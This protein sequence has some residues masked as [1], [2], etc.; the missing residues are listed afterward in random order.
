MV[1]LP[2]AMVAL[3]GPVVGWLVA[4]LVVGARRGPRPRRAAAV[5][6]RVALAVLACAGALRALL[7]SLGAPGGPEGAVAALNSALASP[8]TG[9]WG[10]LVTQTGM[11][12]QLNPVRADLLFPLAALFGLF[13]I[14][15]AIAASLVEA[16]DN[17]SPDYEVPYGGWVALA[18][19]ATTVLGTSMAYGHYADT[20][21]RLLLDFV[22]AGP[23][24]LTCFGIWALSGRRTPPKEAAKEASATPAVNERGDIV[25]RWIDVH[26]LSRDARAVFQEAAIR[27]E[28]GG[29][30]ATEA[31]RNAG[32][33]GAPPEA[34]DQ[35]RALLSG[36][37]GA[38]VVGDLPAP[39]EEF[40]VTAMLVVAAQ[41]LGLPCLVVTDEPGVARDRLRAALR[42]AGAWR[43]GPLTA[44]ADE[45]KQS[46]GDV[47]MPAVAFLSVRELSGDGNRAL[48]T[49]M[50]PRP[51]A[52]PW[53]RTL[54]LCV[55]SRLDRGSP[56]EVTH[57]YFTLRRLSLALA[58]AG[59][60]YAVLATGFG[61]AGTLRLIRHAFPGF[62]PQEVPIGLRESAPVKVWVAEPGFV[63]RAGEPWPRRAANPLVKM[64]PPVPVRVGDPSGHFDDGVG[65]WGGDVVLGRDL[66]LDGAASISLLGDAWLVAGWRTLGNRPPLPDGS[67]HHALWSWEPSPV[68]T[69]L[70]DHNR[71][72]NLK[73]HGHLPTPRALVGAS[74]PH[75]ARAHLQAAMREGRQDQQSLGDIFGADLTEQELK[76]AGGNAGHLLRFRPAGDK[77]ER[78]RAVP[79][80]P[81]ALG[82]VLRETVTDAVV[83]IKDNNGG[84]TIALTDESVANVRFYPH[85]VF[86][87]RDARYRVPQHTFDRARRVIR[88][89]S[90][91]AS[92]PI[93]RPDLVIDLRDPRV[94]DAPQHYTSE[95]RSF[96]YASFD[97]VAHEKVVGAHL[98]PGHVRLDTPE[99]AT[100]PTRVRVIAFDTPVS[101]NAMTHLA[102][103]VDRVVMAHLLAADDDIHVIHAPQGTFP[104]IPA[105]VAAVD[106]YVG[107][108]GV[109][110]ALD[111]YVIDEVLRWVAEILFECPCK[112][113]CERC[114]PPEA[115]SIGPDKDGVLSLLGR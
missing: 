55:I 29:R 27:R 38:W 96:T 86:A 68:T 24:V 103:C 11:T 10:T 111:V 109:A 90:T 44:G 76:A 8:G 64:T 62:R 82:D 94:A 42:L 47:R 110:E 18:V 95:R 98:N 83:E 33:H 53:T 30:V 72:L 100:Y 23:A 102:A 57:R 7:Y 105:G 16:R 41:D 85:R 61:G 26:A 15:A 63:A 66:T 78:V 74:N 101:V 3:C 60:D 52:T 6:L 40:F 106:R 49:C 87:F 73:H 80:L 20:Q 17:A 92:Q 91:D 65:I 13:S 70:R 4:M 51:G 31:W 93:T 39:T 115:L 104:A 79:P 50:E 75:L 2:C 69:Y 22:A 88:V 37:P 21:P 5:F 32:A 1:L 48:W 108:M 9:F 77:L 99:V 28:G 45:F 34:L 67:V 84:V 12:V 14:P 107:G 89:E 19:A 58:S 59:A 43:Y 114:T 113:G 71:L 46:L 54:G 25:Q 36:E 35:L 81:G 56:L 97:V 112:H